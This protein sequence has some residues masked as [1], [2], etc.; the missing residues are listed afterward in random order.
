[1]LSS[2]LEVAMSGG[3]I[4]IQELRIKHFINVK[5]QFSQ[6]FLTELHN[7]LDDR[8][9]YLTS[10]VPLRLL[11][12]RFKSPFSLKK[13]E[14]SQQWG[15]IEV[16]EIELKKEARSLVLNGD[17]E[18]GGL[19][20]LAQI[21]EPDKF[22]IKDIKPEEL[23]GKKTRPPTDKKDR[24]STEKRKKKSPEKSSGKKNV[25]KIR[26]KLKEILV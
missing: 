17:V 6:S 24:Q 23:E 9:L 2:K 3:I 20:E 16:Y 1:N 22:E 12:M 19:V 26:P 14:E 8:T 15:K 11:A 4:E 7:S 21:W 5:L 10:S 18:D 25:V 13:K